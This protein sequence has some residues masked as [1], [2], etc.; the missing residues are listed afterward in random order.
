VPRLRKVTDDLSEEARRVMVLG[1]SEGRSAAFISQAILDATGEQ[2]HERTVSRRA[3]EWRAEVSSRKAARERMEN[4]VAAMKA[5]NMDASEMVQAL[6]MDRL[7]ENPEALTG[8][9]PIQLQ[10]LA[11]K[12]EELRLK[13]QQLAVRERAIEVVERKLKLSEV[14]EQRAIAATAELEKKA[15]QGEQISAADVAKIRAI[16]GLSDGRPEQQQAAS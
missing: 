4:L 10:G 3:S 1:I 6:A 9:D 13:R 14:R 8:A 15:E 7:V 11:L 2:V 5:G 16:Y 12:G